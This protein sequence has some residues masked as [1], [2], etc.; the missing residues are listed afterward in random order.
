MKAYFDD[1]GNLVIEAENQT[2]RVALH[3]WTYTHADNDTTVRELLDSKILGLRTPFGSG[4]L[5][6]AANKQGEKS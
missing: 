4:Q 3:L 1:T 2:E 6:R 5:L